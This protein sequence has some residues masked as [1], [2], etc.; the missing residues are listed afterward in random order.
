MMSPLFLPCSDILFPLQVE[1]KGAKKSEKRKKQ[2]EKE[3]ERKKAAHEQ[4]RASSPV[5]PTSDSADKNK[6]AAASTPAATAQPSAPAA[7]PA[8]AS[9]RAALAAQSPF[10]ALYGLLA[11]AIEARGPAALSDEQRT[12]LASAF[13]G[14]QFGAAGSRQLVSACAARGVTLEVLPDD[15]FDSLPADLPRP[16]GPAEYFRITAPPPLTFVVLSDG[17]PFLT[18]ATKS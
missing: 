17:A 14:L 15:A 1:S 4:K 6:E 3:R 13:E 12:K 10:D 2:K 16:R 5:A 18:Y 7:A 8:A 9:V 11:A